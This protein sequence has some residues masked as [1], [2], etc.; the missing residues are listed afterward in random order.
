VASAP[1]PQR[2]PASGWAWALFEAGRIPL[3]ILV[4]VY[5]FTPYIA[6]VFVPDPVEGQAVVAEAGKW[7]GWIVALTAPLLG[8]TLDRYGPRKPFLAVVTALLALA[9]ATYW[10][11][12]PDGS[13]LTVGMVIAIAAANTV[14]YAYAELAQNSLLPRA[15]PG[16]E[17]RASGYALGLGNAISLAALVFVLFAFVLPANPLFG[18]DKAMHEPD[19]ISAPIAAALMAVCSVWLFLL[20]PD[21][22]RRGRS[23]LAALAEGAN[24][25]KSLVADARGQRDAML[26]LVARMIFADGKV[27]IIL[28]SGVY[29]AGVFGWRTMELLTL[30]LVTSLFAVAGGF[31]GAWLDGRLGPK[32]AIQ[33][34]LGSVLVAQ[35]GI[36][37]TH[38]GQAAWIPVRDAPVWGVPVFDTLPEIVF[39]ALGFV[40]SAAV[41]AAYASSRTMLVRLVPAD[42]AGRFF[43]L[44]ALSGNLTYWLAPT[45]IELATRRFGTQQAGF[46]PVMGLI[47]IGLVILSFVR[48]GGRGRA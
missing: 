31:L 40:N 5:V 41:T 6:T 24:D 33:L 1:L 16:Q 9:T 48:G 37:G 46:V 45:L 47:L 2:L 39:L 23:L 18:L 25:L 7:G 10:F 30:G 34:Q 27:A 35:L 15:A 8:A 14:L 17:H 26:F 12:A 4:T 32:R 28:F 19:R 43:G 13:G 29:A 22:P 42:N 38:A 20:V 36:L 3:V 11:A 44:Y 21:A